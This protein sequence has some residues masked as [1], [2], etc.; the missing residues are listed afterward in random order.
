[1]DTKLTFEIKTGRSDDGSILQPVNKIG[2]WSALLSIVFG[3][4]YVIAQILSWLKVLGYPNDLF[5]LFLPSLFLAPCFLVTVICLHYA[6]NS[7]EKIFSAIGVAFAIIYCAFATLTYF[8]QLGAIVPGV[9]EGTITDTHSLIFKPRSFTMAIDC[10]GYFFMSLSSLFVAFPFKRR[11]SGL[12]GWLLING[13]LI[14]LFIPAY[15]NP[16]LYYIGSVWALSFT[17]S[18]IYAARF[19]RFRDKI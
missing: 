6:V 8:T 14:V 9:I 17:M 11:D 2:Y 3:L 18:M 19:M 5:W 7:S 12:Y 13:S 10:L 16:F 4:G 15:F 1:M